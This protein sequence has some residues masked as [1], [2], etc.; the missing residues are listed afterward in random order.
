MASKNVVKEIAELRSELD[1]HN[2]LYYL[3]AAPEISDRDYDRLMARLVELETEHPD[4]ITP[5]SPTQRVGG[6]PLAEFAT[7]VH[8]VPMLSIDN[9]YSYD[10]VREWD[11][12]VR[13]GLNK[14]EQVKYVVEIKVD[15]VAVSLRYEHGK[16]VL[17]ATR[18]DGERGDDITANL[19]TVRD[20]PLSLHGRAPELL[21]VR[22]EV[23]MPNSELARIN[24]LRR[25]EGERPFE[26]PRNSTAGTLKLLDSRIC[27]QR[28][29]RFVS[30]GLGEA[31]DVHVTS[32]FKITRMLKEWG[33]PISPYTTCYD[34]IEEVIAHAQNWEQKRNSLDF[35]TD[36]LV[37]KVDDLGQRA[38]LGSRS[39]SPRWT[40]A[41]K[42]EAEQAIT[43]IS[44]I[45]VQV[46]KTGKLTPV[47]DLVPVRLAGTTVKRATLHNADE[48][49][50][51]DIRVGDTV[52][53]QKAGEIIP[54]VVRVEH[55][56]RDGSEVPFV[57]PTHCPN[58]GAPVVR[59]AHEVDYRCSNPP[60]ACTEQLKGRLRYFAHRDAMDIDGLG[61]KLIDQLVSTGLV[62]SLADLYR[63]DVPT[64]SGL[65]R[66]GK[67]SAE[68]LVASIE[69]S[70]HRSLD[71]FVAGLAIRHVGTR[72][73]EV[74]A[75]RFKALE[76][77]RTASLAD[78]ESTPEVGP[79]VAASIHDF[80][81]DRDHQQLLDEL[82]AVGL[83]PQPFEPPTAAGGELVFVGKTFVLTG[84]LPKRTRPESEEL[85]KKLGGK[86]SGSVSKMTSFVLAGDEAGSKLDKARQLGVPV[87][88]EEEFER[89]AGLG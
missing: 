65:E 35:Q 31:R 32:Y 68:N 19:R 21:E 44:S 38:R 39:K 1:R 77:L 80:F 34:T 3:D 85:I 54:Q 18:G 75:Q 63:L 17:G 16:L 87:I 56:S 58:C 72:M 41:F 88:D 37:I 24:E 61:E 23:F 79:I 30:H 29:L 14:G 67:K 25:A 22:G 64:L 53:I 46:G 13:K 52:V 43:K 6:A 50:R 47:A 83:S 81:Q 66:M 60:S 4:L 9:T 5:E 36:G 20:I 8:S 73:A 59:D 69:G 55:D 82:A 57:F 74:L 12:R 45:G 15:G 40:I 2:R 33:V 28:R 26:N 48:I 86:V 10:E 27:G 11:V 89:M 76:K 62:R 78:L 42:Y 70:K 49:A 51:K 84:T 7:V 71:R